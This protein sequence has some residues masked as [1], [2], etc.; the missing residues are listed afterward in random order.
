[1]AVSFCVRSL[2]VGMGYPRITGGMVR[3]NQGEGLVTEKIRVQ[4]YDDP[5]GGDFQFKVT[6]GQNVGTYP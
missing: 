5:Q 2:L 1:M 6:G 4:K 3:I